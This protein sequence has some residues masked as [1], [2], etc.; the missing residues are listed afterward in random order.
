LIYSVR[1]ERGKEEAEKRLKCQHRDGDLQKGSPAREP[2]ATYRLG[3]D[4]G[5]PSGMES[6]WVGKFFPSGVNQH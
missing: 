1:I 5:E 2:T 4:I 6:R 3:V